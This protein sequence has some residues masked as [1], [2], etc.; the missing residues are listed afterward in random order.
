M[1][2]KLIVLESMKIARI[3]S[4]E[5]KKQAQE[6][7]EKRENELEE[8]RR[9]GSPS[10]GAGTPGAPGK[11]GKDGADGSRWYTG[12]GAPG[13]AQS[14]SRAVG[15]CILVVKKSSVKDE[16]LAAEFAAK[17]AEMLEKGEEIAKKLYA[18]IEG[19]L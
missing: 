19:G 9:R 11:D 15:D 16:A 1:E 4:E 7:N 14:S 2:L 10:T 13:Y 6:E 12:S 3:L 5:K 18:E 8:L 17:G